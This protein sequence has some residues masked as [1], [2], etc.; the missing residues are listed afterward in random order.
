MKLTD[1]LIE[2]GDEIEAYQ[3]PST[4]KTRQEYIS[5][6]LPLMKWTNE[7]LQMGVAMVRTQ[8]EQTA[9]KTKPKAIIIGLMVR[10]GKLF[11]GF[12]QQIE[13]GQEDIASIFARL[14]FETEVKISYLIKNPR[15]WKSYV[16]TSLRAEREMLEDLR[17]KGKTRKLIPIEKR[18]QKSVR[19]S[20][21]TAGTT[22]K[23]LLAFKKHREIDG[24][25]FRGLLED[26]NREHEYIYGFASSSRHVHGGWLDLHRYHLSKKGRGFQPNIKF[27]LP[28]PRMAGPLTFRCLEAILIY[29]A[30]SKGDRT[31]AIKLLTE[32][33]LKDVREID[34]MHEH[35]LS[36][37]S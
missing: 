28:D 19:R 34:D 35:Q 26:L 5:A 30:W 9:G 7:L 22:E 3:I 23:E 6:L 21:K 8:R 37:G 12:V 25:N 1:R 10:L 36:A 27:R 24:K 18:I 15:S 16:I 11:H 17:A 31:G 20:L 32:Q 29:I 2:I 13:C 14:I 4:L 33:L